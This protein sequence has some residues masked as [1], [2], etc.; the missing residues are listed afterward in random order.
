MYPV[1]EL[2][3]L[4]I[5]V[6]GLCAL[7]GLLAA[8]SL[9]IHIARGRLISGWDVLYSSLYVV[10]GIII[11]AKVLYFITKIPALIMAFDII[12]EYPFKDVVE[13][14]FGG[15]VFYGG[16]IGAAVGFVRYCVRYKLPVAPLAESA[17]PAV[18]LFHAFG[19][20]GC[21]F[22]GCCYGVEYHGPFAI[23][24]PFNEITKDMAGVPRFPA[25]IAEAVF[26][27]LLCIVLAIFIRKRDEDVKYVWRGTAATEAAK[28]AKAAG[29]I[30]DNTGS[31]AEEACTPNAAC[32][33]ASENT[34]SGTEEVPEDF[35]VTFMGRRIARPRIYRKPFAP[36]G[37]Y[38]VCYG[39][40]RFCIEFLRNDTDRGGIGPFS[41]S[42]W[43]SLVL[44]PLG[45]WLLARKQKTSK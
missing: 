28:A 3:I 35:I 23:T 12:C 33:R 40:F 41:T 30:Q 37:L 21:L 24:Y 19:R 43:V 13:Y 38:L 26:N 11:G 10:A 18:P 16:L 8:F 6:Y 5:P 29:D 4:Q 34:G 1:I 7:I 45:I 22:A 36:A 2:G 20:I 15:Y 14:L 9:Y 39:V 32:S 42:Q 27:V 44:V 25:P 17:M 31:Q